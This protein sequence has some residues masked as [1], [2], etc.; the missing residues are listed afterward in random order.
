[1][2]GRTA[3]LTFILACAAVSEPAAEEALAPARLWT[4]AVPLAPDA[5]QHYVSPGGRAEN[6]G[7]QDSPW[8]LSGVLSGQR[9]IP[10]GSIVWVRGGRYVYPVRDSAKGRNGFVVSLSGAEGKPI[11][12]R[13]WPGERATIDGG[14]EV[15]AGHLWIWDLEFALGD[16]WRPKEPSPQGQDTHFNTPTGVLNVDSSNENVKVIN[17]ISH[18][19]HMGIGLWKFLKGGEV[20]GCIVYDNGFL[21]TDR[22][23]GPALY[24]QNQTGTPHLITDNILGGNYSL[25]LQAYASNMDLWVNDFTIEGNIIWAPRQEARGRTFALCGGNRSKNMV[26]RRNFVYGHQ[27]RVG[28]EA[29]QVVEGN[30][31]VRGEFSAPTPERNTLIPAPAADTPPILWLH[32]NKYD[33]RRANLLV[34]NWAKAGRVE[35]DLSSFLGDGEAYWILSPFDFY[36]KP[37]AE[38]TYDGK[39]VSLPVTSIPWTLMTGD[40][41]EL[42]VYIVLGRDRVYSQP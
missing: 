42:G 7:T 29:G 33:P 38:G 2:A 41:K 8:D 14:F 17:C 32:P 12:V 24:T 11:H 5:P 36:G 18:N 9:P 15:S 16:D 4:K 40:P 31:I 28:S 37:L 30:V 10:P 25:P 19:N 35:A 1:M 39:P 22:P 34:T 27:L 21:G 20:H 6:L 26:I 23:H 3:W 13:A